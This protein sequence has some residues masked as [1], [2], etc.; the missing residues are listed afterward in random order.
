[1]IKNDFW[2]WTFVILFGILYL[3]LLVTIGVVVAHF[4]GKI[5]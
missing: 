2:F 1:M 4:I 5:W 3:I